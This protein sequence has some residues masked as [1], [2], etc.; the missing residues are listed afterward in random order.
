MDGK[1]ARSVVP[2]SGV[3]AEENACSRG[4]RKKGWRNTEKQPADAALAE[5]E[6]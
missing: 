3:S 4:V 6:A 2:D 5:H 1:E